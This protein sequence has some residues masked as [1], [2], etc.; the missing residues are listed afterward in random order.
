MA[1]AQA[2][3]TRV[4]SVELGIEAQCETEHLE[5]LVE[6]MVAQLK[7]QVATL[8]VIRH[9]LRRHRETLRGVTGELAVS[10]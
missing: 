1:A 5:T 3:R 8:A 7:T 9:G 10:A 6:A 2:D 4:R